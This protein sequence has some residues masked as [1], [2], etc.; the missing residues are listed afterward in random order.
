MIGNLFV[1]VGKTDT[2]AISLEYCVHFLMIWF[3]YFIVINRIGFNGGLHPIDRACLLAFVCVFCCCG[4]CSATE[5]LL[6][7]QV[8][9]WT[10]TC[11]CSI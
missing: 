1:G 4:L 3:S 11:A 9:A 2:H 5:A 10:T 8:G 7:Q 6:I